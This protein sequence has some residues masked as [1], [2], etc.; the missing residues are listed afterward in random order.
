MTLVLGVYGVMFVIGAVT[1]WALS[2]A[3]VVQSATK[4]Y[5]RMPVSHFVLLVVGFAGIFLAFPRNSFVTFFF[6]L[7]VIVLIQVPLAL[8]LIIQYEVS[9]GIKRRKSEK[10]KV[11]VFKRIME[12]EPDSSYARL[13]LALTYEK[14]GRFLEAA[15][16]Y[17]ALAASLTEAQYG[18]RARLKRKED[19]LR[20]KSEEEQKRRTF[21]CADC[22]AR[23][24]PQRRVCLSCGKALHEDNFRWLWRSL[25]NPLKF[26]ALAVIGLSFCFVSVV[27]PLYCIA[28][29]L[30]WL[31]I[32]LYV[33]L[34]A[35]VVFAA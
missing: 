30:I 3:Y 9:S 16:E 4:A 17:E 15:L 5:D 24:R 33:S 26:S 34:L 29:A 19:L 22:G 2:W 21:V 12:R 8:F 11:A 23:N 7:V 6:A 27:P 31:V 18:Y 32:V 13:N 25:S 14:Y 28:L 10:A 35:G 1:L 20:R